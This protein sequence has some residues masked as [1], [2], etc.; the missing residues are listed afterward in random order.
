[1]I[2]PDI[3]IK[4]GSDG[5]DEAHERAEQIADLLAAEL[6]RI[7]HNS[8]VGSSRAAPGSPRSP[9]LKLVGYPATVVFECIYEE[10]R[11]GALYSGLVNCIIVTKTGRAVARSTVVEPAK[12]G[13]DYKVLAAKVLMLA[14]KTRPKAIGGR[15]VVLTEE[16]L[17][18]ITRFEQEARGCVVVGSAKS[19]TYSLSA[20]VVRDLRA[21]FKRIQA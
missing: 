17:H 5:G 19:V 11:D 13:F 20:S 14:S 16:D 6:K 18:V 12:R 15:K 4:P 7:G 8:R 21:I 10:D 1:M 9:T 3:E 2:P